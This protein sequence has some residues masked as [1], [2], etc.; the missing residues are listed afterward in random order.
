MP[1]NKQLG[2]RQIMVGLFPVG[3]TGLDEI[4]EDL[5]RAQLA[6]TDELAAELV[7]RAR[8]HNYVPASAEQDFRAALVLE[9]LKFYEAKSTGQP[10]TK[11]EAWKGIPREQVP[12]FPVLDET[13]CDGCD[14]CLRF[15]ANGVYAKRDNGVVYVSEAFNCVVGCDACARL[16]RHAAI[17]FPPRS[18]LTSMGAQAS[19]GGIVRLG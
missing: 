3:M 5:Y 16:C 1:D 4:F 15:C 19:S 18:I 14:K 11:R 12:W 17:V 13:L 2:Y 10:L 8:Q 9:Y 6:P 7:S